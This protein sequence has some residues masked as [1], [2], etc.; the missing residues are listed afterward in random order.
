MAKAHLLV[1]IETPDG[2]EDDVL[3][4]LD[5]ILGAHLDNALRIQRWQLARATEIAVPGIDDQATAL[6]DKMN[7]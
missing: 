5:T 1:T 7:N 4:T 3:D 6:Y 2:F